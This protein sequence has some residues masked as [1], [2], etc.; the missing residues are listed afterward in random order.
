MTISPKKPDFILCIPIVCLLTTGLVMVRSASGIQS[1]EIFQDPNEIFFKQLVALGIGL[2]LLI[3]LTHVR[4]DFLKHPVILYAGV[5]AVTALLVAVKLQPAANGAQ[6]WFF[7]GNFGFQPSDLAKIILIIFIAAHVTKPRSANMGW[8]H[9]LVPVGLLMGLFCGLIL[10]QPDFGT[11]MILIFV[12]GALL[13]LAGLPWVYFLVSIALLLPI[14]AGLI[15]TEG[16]R[17]QRIRDFRASEAPYQTRQ[18][19]IAL[20]SGG[21]TGVGLGEGKQK[22]Y[23]LPQPHTDFIFATV[24][25][26]LGFFGT[27]FIVA[28]YLLLFW[29]GIFVLCRV[30]SMYSKILGAGILLLILTQALLNMS[31]TLAL[32]PNKGLTLPFISAG[33]T[34]LILCLGICGILLNISRY[35][36]VEN[37]VRT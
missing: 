10:W 3:S 33:G 24:G 16:Y 36:I 2:V 19:V 35:Q 32:F 1:I 4:H 21:L 11:T 23:F 9:R 28:M 12:A 31:V 22:L 34:S 18:S 25:E 15:L 27:S 14:V 6:R 26:E 8:A 29:R 20:G 37:K 17:V 13:F 5:I 30:E 7:L